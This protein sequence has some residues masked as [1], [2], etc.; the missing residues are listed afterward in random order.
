MEVV[1]EVQG[2]VIHVQ[3]VAFPASNFFLFFFLLF[4]SFSKTSL[5]T[6]KNFMDLCRDTGAAVPVKNAVSQ[7][8]QVKR[9]TLSQFCWYVW[10]EAWVYV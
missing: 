7:A 1:A 10:V 5:Q 9:L 6:L 2:M 8:E 4:S 3:L